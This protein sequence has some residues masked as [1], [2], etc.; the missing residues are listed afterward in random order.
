LEA[1]AAIFRIECR[2]MAIA[3][4][5]DADEL[6]AQV[7]CL[8]LLSFLTSRPKDV[9]ELILLRCAEMLG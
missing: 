7:F 6:A 1:L 2:K 9:L 4:Y 3:S 5:V 8:A